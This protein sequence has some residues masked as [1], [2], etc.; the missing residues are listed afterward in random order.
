MDSEEA[1]METPAE[2]GVLETDAVRVRNLEEGDLE[3]VVAIDAEATG[4]RRP[5]Y[6]GLLLQRAL[7]K[8]NL[9]VSLVAE[10]D[11][12]VVGFLMSSVV[13]GE[14]GVVEPAATIDAIGVDPEYRG[15]HVA[16]ALMRQLRLNLSAL[17]IA[18]VRTEVSWDDFELLAFFKHEG[19]APSGRLCLEMPLDP[20][21]PVC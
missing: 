3:R 17:R 2:P 9:Q 1:A 20:T 11:E 5:D 18:T 4:R 12:R 10:L 7:E 6:F 14:F 8:S 13:Y 15:R 19:F 16:R 21:A